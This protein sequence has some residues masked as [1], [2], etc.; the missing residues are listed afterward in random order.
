MRIAN[1]SPDIIMLVEVIPKAQVNPIDQAR[2]LPGF[3]AQYNFDP[4]LSN[5][6]VSGSLG[7]A[8]FVKSSICAYE[9][10]DAELFHEQLWLSIPLTNNDLLQIMTYYC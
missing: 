7:I 8:I 1:D 3:N 9:F 10:H 6:G 2:Y 4:S 5:L